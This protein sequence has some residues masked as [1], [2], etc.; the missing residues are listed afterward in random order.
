[1][2]NLLSGCATV[3]ATDLG[4]VTLVIPDWVSITLLG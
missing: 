3:V 1:L 2:S 4:P